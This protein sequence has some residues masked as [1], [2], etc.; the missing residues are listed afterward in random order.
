LKIQIDEF[1]QD[2]FQV[3]K[4][5]EL[6]SAVFVSLN[7]TDIVSNWGQQKAKDSYQQVSRQF[8]SW[9]SLFS[10]CWTNK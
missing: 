6:S 8:D 3:F 9:C 7:Q 1:D 5:T 2:L 10:M 4:I